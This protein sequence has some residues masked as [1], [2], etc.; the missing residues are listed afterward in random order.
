MAELAVT[1]Y[2]QSYFAAD[3]YEDHKVAVASVRAGNVIGG[4]DFAD[5]RLVPD[6]MRALMA[7]K[8]VHIRNPLS[9]RPW[10]HVLEPLAGYLWLGA[11]LLQEGPPFAEPWNFGPPEQKGVTAQALVEKVIALW[12]SGSWLHTQPEL[13]SVETGQ[14]RLSWDKAASRLDWRPVYSWEEMLDEIVAW[15]KAFQCARDMYEI[16]CQHIQA[17]VQRAREVDVGWVRGFK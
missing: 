5:F 9:V 13:A 16:G 11:R 7:E 2:R 1:S 6:C 4:G 14:L 10:Q 12:G 17:Y 3:K 8:P 15:F